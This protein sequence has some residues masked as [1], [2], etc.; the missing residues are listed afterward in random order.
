[1]A[2]D[3]NFQPRTPLKESGELITHVDEYGDL[4]RQ[5]FKTFSSQSQEK[6]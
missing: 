2:Q 3:K 6:E 1:M 5:N 4:V